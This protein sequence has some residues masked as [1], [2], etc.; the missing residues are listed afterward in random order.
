MPT[1][2]ANPREDALNLVGHRAAIRGLTGHPELNGQECTITDFRAD[3]SRYDVV[4]DGKADGLRVRAA[5]LEVLLCAGDTVAIQGLVSRADLNGREAKLLK[6]LPERGRWNVRVAGGEL[7]VKRE[8]LALVKCAS[9]PPH[10]REPESADTQARPL[11]AAEL[12]FLRQATDAPVQLH[13]GDTY[14]QG[15][16][17]VVQSWA[18]G[19]RFYRLAAEQGNATAQSRIGTCYAWGLGMALDLP[20]AA[21]YSRLAAEQGKADAQFDYGHLLESGKGGVKRDLAEAVRWY[22][23]VVAQHDLRALAQLGVCYE[24]GRGMA[25]SDAEAS[26]SYAAAASALNGLDGLFAMGVQYLKMIGERDAS[27]SYTT[28]LAVRELV[29]AGRLGHVGALATLAL[30]SSRREVASACCMGCGATRKLLSCGKCGIARSCDRACQLRTWPM[31]KPSCQQWRDEGSSAPTRDSEEEEEVM[32]LASLP[33]KEIK[34]RLDRLK[35]N[36]AGVL[37]RAELVA[38]LEEV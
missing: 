20:T 10:V 8:N 26:A 29:F 21:R 16:R 15:R 7:A 24:K 11:L 1:M 14:V 37:E 3:D 32:D 35:I 33:I 34:R 17:G 4:L 38:L 5:N 28:Q 25:Q 13:L 19:C 6:H 18:E 9:R 2:A 27:D 31:H 22:R 36:Y 12:T 23:A 30:I